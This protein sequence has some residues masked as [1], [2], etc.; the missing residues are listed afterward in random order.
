[1][2]KASRLRTALLIGMGLLLSFLLHLLIAFLIYIKS[3]HLSFVPRNNTTDPFSPLDFSLWKNPLG[4]NGQKKE[5]QRNQNKKNS[6]ISASYRKNGQILQNNS[7]EK[8]LNTPPGGDKNTFRPASATP[9]ELSQ[10]KNFNPFLFNK[11]PSEIKSSD[12][13]LP[14]P[15]SLDGTG[16]LSPM[17]MKKTISQFIQH[18]IAK[19]VAKPSCHF[20]QRASIDT[21]NP[22]RMLALKR[23]PSYLSDNKNAHFAPHFEETPQTNDLI[24]PIGFSD[25]AESNF[26]RSRRLKATYC[27]GSK[28]LISSVVFN[29]NKKGHLIVESAQTTYVSGKI[30]QWY[31]LYNIFM[32]SPLPSPPSTSLDEKGE[33]TILWKLYRQ[34]DCGID[35]VFICHQ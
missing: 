10:S 17:M 34:A 16:F 32:A 19:G 1:M 6:S 18:T 24:I 33:A 26:A 3:P 27:I 4:D 12:D 23:L 29:I 30:S 11:P 35:E 9:K 22:Q 8:A 5:T 14:T 31:L 7:F 2:K 20:W 13:S 21:N 28:E 15:S 25:E